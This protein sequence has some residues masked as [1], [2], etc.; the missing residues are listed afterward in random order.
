MFIIISNINEEY[1]RALNNPLLY[2][3]NFNLHLIRTNYWSDYPVWFKRHKS[4]IK[5]EPL[6]C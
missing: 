1:L 6:E 5:T 2:Q 4:T 3:N